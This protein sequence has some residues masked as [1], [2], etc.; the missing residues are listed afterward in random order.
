MSHPF[1]FFSTLAMRWQ[2]VTSAF[3]KAETEAIP[4]ESAGFRAVGSFRHVIVGCRGD[5]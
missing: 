1:E 5:D 2:A 4:G 3:A